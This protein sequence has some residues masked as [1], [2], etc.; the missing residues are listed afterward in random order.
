[1]CFRG[2]VSQ[3]L[4]GPWPL[5]PDL[6]PWN[7]LQALRITVTEGC[8][9]YFNMYLAASKLR[10]DWEWYAKYF[11][12]R[13]TERQL[14]RIEPTHAVMLPLFPESEEGL[15]QR[16]WPPP[17]RRACRR[18]RPKEGDDA[19]DP[20]DMHDGA[21]SEESDH[22]SNDEHGDGDDEVESK[23]DVIAILEENMLAMQQAAHASAAKP[24]D[25]PGL[26]PPPPENSSDDDSSSSSSSSTNVAVPGGDDPDAV[27]RGSADAVLRVPGGIM[28]FYYNKLCFTAECT[29]HHPGC[30]KTRQSTAGK[31]RGRHPSQNI[32]AKGRPCGY[33]A[34]WLKMGTAHGCDTKADHWKDDPSFADRKAARQALVDDDNGW[35]MLMHERDMRADEENEEPEGQA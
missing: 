4:C 22:D 16:F 23:R 28:R 29:R 20:D 31:S 21:D 12:L 13:Q 30:V 25:D 26:D 3:T 7:Y 5:Q 15:G 24:G 17:V 19:D 10:S 32:L 14:T 2:H 27:L 34:A 11:Q 1:M 9:T 35:Q 6:T 8:N 33:L 18:P